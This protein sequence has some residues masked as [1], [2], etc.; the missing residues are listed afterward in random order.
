[1]HFILMY[2]VDSKIIIEFKSTEFDIN[3]NSL[4][5]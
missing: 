2:Y 1:M 3:P 4:K 5:V